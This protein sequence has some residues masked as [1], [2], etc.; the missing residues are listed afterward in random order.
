MTRASTKLRV[1]CILA[2]GLP[3]AAFAE[4]QPYLVR[5]LPGVTVRDSMP[6]GQAFWTTTGDVS[7][8]IAS[9]TS[10]SRTLEIFKT[11]GTASGT[12]QV[13][14]GSGVPDAQ[15]LGLFL[16]T[17]G[18]RLV[19]GGKDSGGD[20]LFALDS[21]GGDPI[22]LGRFNLQ[23]LTNG[24][25]RGD[26]LY[27]SGRSGNEHEL[28]RTDGTIQGTSKIDL[29][30]GSAGAFDA[31]RDTRL[32]SAGPWIFFYGQTPQG[33]GLLRTD[34]TA[35]N[36]AVL[37]PL[38]ASDLF[39]NTDAAIPLGD[40][41]VFGISASPGV[42]IWATDG[43]Q[44]GTSQIGKAGS[45]IPMGIVAGKLFFDGNGLW[46][47]DGTASGTRLTDVFAT[48]PSLTAGGVAGDRL[49]FFADTFEAGRFVK[50]LYVTAGTAATTHAI[51]I[52]DQHSA[53]V[54]GEGFVIGNDFYF[55]NDDGIHGMEIWRTD[56]VSAQMA[57]D[58]NPGYRDGIDF[59]I[60]EERSDGR[61]LFAATDYNTGR[62]PWITD[63]TAGGTHLL[64][65]IAPD[66]PPSGSSPSQL[67]ASG[68]R[69]F[70]TAQLPGGMAIGVSDGTSSGTTATL[71]E[72]S[73]FAQNPA[74][75]NDLYFFS[76][77]KGAFA[78]DEFARV[79]RILDKPASSYPFRNGV[80]L[81][82]NAGDFWFSDGTTGGTRKLATFGTLGSFANVSIVGSVAWV[83]KGT[84]LWITDGTQQGTVEVVPTTRPTGNVSSF[85]QIAGF[86]YFF[87]SSTFDHRVRLWRSDG[88]SA[89][90]SMVV[91]L[92]G[93]SASFFAVTERI[94][95]FVMDGKL[96]R[97]DG[98][99]EGTSALAAP[100]GPCPSSAAIL[101]GALLFETVDPDRTATV[102]R[103]DGTD[104]GTK[105][106]ATMRPP[107]NV[108]VSC[109][110]IRTLG[111]LAY[112][113]GWDSAHGWEPWV[114]DGTAAGTKMLSDIYP[115]TLGSA[116]SEFTRAGSHLF[117]SADSPGTGREL[118]AVGSNAASRR[119][120]VH[121]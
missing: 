11:D 99:L 46:V 64:A 96:Y 23:S 28:W 49:F 51:A 45:F 76:T 17:I 112:F 98:T 110:D 38:T 21:S 104:A 40:R 56:G 52:V 41:L 3:L 30:P 25:V 39:N 54:R 35:E 36:T 29:M 121:H 60:A 62:E 26:A 57:F 84:R 113:A 88:T 72:F 119:R 65:N 103:T 95:F 31:S 106:L 114:S 89:G 8:F 94:A 14:H 90:T 22:L 78:S 107:A 83:G 87:E 115:G 47:T 16:G 80:L 12:R 50:R 53:G 117:F 32:Y 67:R 120:T 63:G 79:N 69:V 13:T 74:A 34:G 9:T 118:W 27:F 82:D 43:T 48:T 2:V 6:F 86:T 93:S 109:Q 97:T 58:I 61:V 111:D 1:L 44:A 105:Q 70:F 19:Y 20:G 18:G 37:L 100:Q 108:N 92:G 81:L 59:L 101:G 24:V 102:W 68:D 116:P 66:T 10:G 71:L 73:E 55:R 42:Q 77:S 7:W 91:D 5:D 4:L 85:A 33:S 75:A 15:S